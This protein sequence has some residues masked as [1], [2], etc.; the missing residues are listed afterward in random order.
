MAREIAGSADPADDSGLTSGRDPAGDEQEVSVAPQWKLVWWSFKRHRM[1]LVGGIITIFIYLVALFA[2]FLAPY[3]NDSFDSEYAYAPPQ[4]LHVVDD[5]EWGL[6]VHGYRAEQDPETLE[7][8]WEI[9]ESQKIPVGLFVRGEEYELFGLITWDR[10]LIGPKDYDGPPMYLLGADELGHDM[11]S[12]IIHGTAVSMSIGLVGVILSFLL[13]VVLGGI[14]GYFGGW[15]DNLIQRITEFVISIPTIPLWMGLMA[16]IPSHWGPLQRYFALTVILSLI[17]WAG[18]GREVR[19]KFY[20]VRDEEF[21]MAAT[22]DGASQPRIIFRHMLP[23]FTSHIIANMSLAIPAMILAETALSFIGI[24]LQEPTVSWGVLLEEAQ[25]IRVLESAPWM[26]LPG[27]AV[28]VAVLS[29]N[30]FGDGLRD[31][32]DPYKS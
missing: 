32:A 22:V 4:R 25:S 1:A 18:L 19:G 11:L 3:S 30:F 13:G 29:L 21:V 7:L 27:V 2:G 24:G 12:R 14:S 10:H 17:S 16:A 15:V 31:A 9:D 23:S 20:A 5:G 26:M 8:S 28:I 6:H